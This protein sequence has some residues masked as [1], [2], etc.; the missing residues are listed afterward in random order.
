MQLWS[1]LATAHA[2]RAV[3]AH[4]IGW[5]TNAARRRETPADASTVFSRFGAGNPPAGNMTPDGGA[6]V[7][8][9]GPDEFLV[10]AVHARVDFEPAVQSPV[11]HR[12]FVRVEE[13][14][15]AGHDWRFERIWNGDQTDYGLNF[16]SAPQVLRVR[17]ATY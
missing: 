14:I 6:M 5:E 7:A 8:Q 10:T 17:L 13:G 16:T 3:P 15:Y 4:K 11:K 1:K 9:L 2:N 12:Q